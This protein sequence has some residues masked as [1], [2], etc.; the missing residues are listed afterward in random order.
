[1]QADPIGHLAQRQQALAG[2][3]CPIFGGRFR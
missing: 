2:I 1:V 3:I